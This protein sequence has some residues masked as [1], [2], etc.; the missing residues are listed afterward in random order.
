MDVPVWT[1]CVISFP[2][3]DAN[4]ENL[5]VERQESKTWKVWLRFP[6]RVEL[7]KSLPVGRWTVVTSA[8][9][10][11]GGG[12]ACERSEFRFPITM[13]TSDDISHGKPDPEP[14]LKAAARLGYRS[15]PS[16]WWLKMRRPESAR[17]RQRER[18]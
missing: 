9:R 12:A 11:A 17:E 8:T 18:E 13:I 10:R 1:R 16:A 7:V 3:A 6:E 4:A 5:E 2:T 14:Y 15:R